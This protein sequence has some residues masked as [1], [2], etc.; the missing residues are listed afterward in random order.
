[1]DVQWPCQSTKGSLGHDELAH[2][3]I[4]DPDPTSHAG[5]ASGYRKCCYAWVDKI[6]QNLILP[7]SCTREMGHH[8]QHLA[9]TGDVVAAVHTELVPAA[10]ATNV[11]V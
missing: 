1:M 11:L 9:G 8:G 2:V 5:T 10:T 3:T 6:T 7:W 4:G